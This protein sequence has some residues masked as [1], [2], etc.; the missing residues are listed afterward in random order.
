MFCSIKYYTSK[1]DCNESLPSVTEVGSQR[2]NTLP[3]LGVGWGCEQCADSIDCVRGRRMET[4]LWMQHYVT[5]LG[6]QSLSLTNYWGSSQYRMTGYRMRQSQQRSGKR[7]ESPVLSALRGSWEWGGAGVV[8]SGLDNGDDAGGGHFAGWNWPPGYSPGETLQGLVL[9]SQ[10][11][12]LQ[13][14]AGILSGQLVHLL[15]Q[16]CLLSL[17]LFLLGDTLDATAGCIASVLQG[18]SPLLQ[19]DDIFLRQSTQML[20]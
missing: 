2:P 16:L 7:M 14:H 20:V 10:C 4:E 11:I 13:P 1:T 5:E 15:L 19:P 3:V 17:Q 18:P 9:S 8:V 6:T 12:Q